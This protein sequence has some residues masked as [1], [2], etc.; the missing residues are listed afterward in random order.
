MVAPAPSITAS[1]TGTPRTAPKGR[2]QPSSV[3][4]E[5]DTVTTISCVTLP[6]TSTQN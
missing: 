6:T 4:Q 1:I 2:L 3:N 5:Q